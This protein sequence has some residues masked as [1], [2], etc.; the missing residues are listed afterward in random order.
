M[1]KRFLIVSLSLTLMISC[2]GTFGSPEGNVLSQLKHVRDAMNQYNFKQALFILE[3]LFTQQ[4][5]TPGD[6]DV[7]IKSMEYAGECSFYLGDLTQSIFYNLKASESLDNS[8]TE[9][10]LTLKYKS[11]KAYFSKG[12]VPKAFDLFFQV[13]NHR[14]ISIFPALQADALMDAGMVHFLRGNYFQ[15]KKNLYSAKRI[16]EKLKLKKREARTFYYLG[17]IFNQ[18]RD[19]AFGYEKFQEAKRLALETKD[20]VLLFMIYIEEGQILTEWGK[21]E[22]ALNLF[23]EALK[24]FYKKNIH[25]GLIKTYYAMGSLFFNQGDYSKAEDY[26][27]TGRDLLWQNWYLQD[28]SEY[29]NKL[30]EL[31]TIKNSYALAENYTKHALAINKKLKNSFNIIL[32]QINLG[33]IYKKQ[34]K[35]SLAEN[36]L[37]E[38]LYTPIRST[39]PS[40]YTPIA[41]K[42][43]GDIYLLQGHIEKSIENYKIAV[44]KSEKCD[45][46]PALALYLKDLGFAYMK[47]QKIDRAEAA[48]LQSIGIINQLWDN[49]PGEVKREYMER[50]IETYQHLISLYIKMSEP[51]KAFN[52]MEESTAKYFL[53][54]IT[55]KMNFQKKNISSLK[56]FQTSLAVPSLLI[57]YANISRDQIARIT[58][59]RSMVTA[60]VLETPDLPFTL[61]SSIIQRM[62]GNFRGIYTV[63]PSLYNI[64]DEKTDLDFTRLINVFRNLCS[65]PLLSKEEKVLFRKTG[66]ILYDLLLG[67]MNLKNKDSLIIKPGGLLAFLPFEALIMPDGRYL[68]EKYSIQ[69]IHSLSVLNIIKQRKYKEDR[70][71][72]LAFGGADY[73]GLKPKP[74]TFQSVKQLALYKKKFEKDQF[75]GK[76]LKSFYNRLYEEDWSQLVYSTSE[77]EAIGRVTLDSDLLIGGDVTEGEIKK[78]SR[79]GK[80]KNYKTL[81]FAVHGIVDPEIPETSALV[82]S[83]V[84]SYPEDGYLTMKEIMDLNIEADFVNLSACETGLGKLYNS[85]G[86]VGLTQAFIIAGAN[87][88]SVSLWKI[89]DKSTEVFMKKLYSLL[90]EGLTIPAALCKVKREFIISRKSELPFYWAPFVYYG[91]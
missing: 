46:K 90:S 82:L 42:N 44:K 43:L 40:L 18:E 65:K 56:D 5:I 38:A 77:V 16:N 32:N 80:L 30:G 62:P 27:K 45:N 89:S 33:N 48:F 53:S 6:K 54:R 63:Q 50:A 67:G 72:M 75:L 23:D 47:L 31:Y 64:N 22:E 91:E 41:H 83:R 29:F 7:Y 28:Q 24:F 20:Q 9:R 51:Y 39:E 3:K 74:K 15:A 87:S 12:D 76:N 55:E 85:E 71:N 21:Y 86:V 1:K 49:T 10:I 11:G 68:V 81:H 34:E 57:S 13:L 35:Y 84:N 60:D 8:Q 73:N 58:A 25:N 79:E 52:I 69:Y 37:L 61:P 4:I 17:Q 2:A 88:L 70:K 78:L 36:Y 59:G 14:D 66:R 19:L 26:L